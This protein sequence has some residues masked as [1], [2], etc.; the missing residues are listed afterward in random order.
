[1]FG[2][3]EIIYLNRIAFEQGD[4]AVLAIIRRQRIE[5]RHF[6]LIQCPEGKANAPSADATHKAGRLATG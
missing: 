4:H 3:K 6:R 2:L 1:M 5:K